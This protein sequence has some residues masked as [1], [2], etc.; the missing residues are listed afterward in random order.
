V[1]WDAIGRDRDA[2]TRWLDERV[3][4]VSAGQS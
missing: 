3:Y 4:A 1:A 2:F